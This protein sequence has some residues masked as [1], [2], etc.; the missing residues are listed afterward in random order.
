MK[1]KS[2]MVFNI[3]KLPQLKWVVV[4]RVILGLSLFLKGIQFIQDKSEIRKV[5]T[6]SLVLREYFWLQTVIPWLNILCG[7]FI[8][9]GLFTRLMTIIQIPIMIGAIVF[10]N[11]KHGAFEG[12]S[13]L[14]LSIVILV[15]LFFFLFVGGGNFAWDQVLRK[16]DKTN[17]ANE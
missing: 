11:S 15:L 13:N 7:F 16:E 17:Y 2:R 5:F 14:A 4:F 3:S 10:V 8:V 1:I 12:E 9:I 6:E